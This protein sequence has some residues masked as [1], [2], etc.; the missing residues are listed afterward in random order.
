M[1]RRERYMSLNAS[2]DLGRSKIDKFFKTRNAE[3]TNHYKEQIRKEQ[4][5]MKHKE[6]TIKKLT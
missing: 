4:K 6:D 1:S 2:R 3:H 5:T